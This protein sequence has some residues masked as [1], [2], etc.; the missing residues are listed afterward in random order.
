VRFEWPGE[1]DICTRYQQF[2][3]SVEHFSTADNVH[4]ADIEPLSTAEVRCL[5]D[6]ARQGP[7]RAKA[8]E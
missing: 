3:A 5:Y 8:T 6:E 7:S 2:L 1:Q 4:A